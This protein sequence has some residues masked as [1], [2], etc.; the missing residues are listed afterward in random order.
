MVQ[1]RRNAGE[2]LDD[3]A[4]LLL[5]ARRVLGG[6]DEMGRSSYQVAMCVCEGCGRGWHRGGGELIAVDRE[7]VAMS[8]CDGQRLPTAGPSAREGATGEPDVT[9]VGNA[10]ESTTGGRASKRTALRP[11]RRV[12]GFV[13]YRR[14]ISWRR[15]RG[16]A[17]AGVLV[18]R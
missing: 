5:L 12:E 4:A 17:K 15:S 3:D 8:A 18:R 1:L 13:D 7:V 6:P 10:E 14:C 2:R 11:A 16:F 9:H